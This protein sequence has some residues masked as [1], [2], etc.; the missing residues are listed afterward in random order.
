MQKLQRVDV[1]QTR[2]MREKAAALTRRSHV[3]YVDGG[4]RRGVDEVKRWWMA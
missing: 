1:E 4:R 2:E 3:R